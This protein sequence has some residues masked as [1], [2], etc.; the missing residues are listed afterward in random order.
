MLFP[1]TINLQLKYVMRGLFY[2]LRL[3]L[4][5]RYKNEE[6]SNTFPSA[7]EEIHMEIPLFGFLLARD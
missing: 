6:I 2:K 5:D 7:T 1:G 3:F 4:G